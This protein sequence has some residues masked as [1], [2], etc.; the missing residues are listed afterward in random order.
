[1]D[2][3]MWKAESCANDKSL[4]AGAL[5]S[6]GFQ[7]ITTGKNGSNVCDSGELQNILSAKIETHKVVACKAAPRHEGVLG[8]WR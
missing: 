5:V 4:P 2:R 8:E 6:Y 7:F 3:R 1:M